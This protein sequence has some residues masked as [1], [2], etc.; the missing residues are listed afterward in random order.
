MRMAI[1]HTD[2]SKDTITFEVLNSDDLLQ[3]NKRTNYLAAL[4]LSIWVDSGQYVA[5]NQKKNVAGT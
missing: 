2:H 1:D 4:S 5:F 3:N